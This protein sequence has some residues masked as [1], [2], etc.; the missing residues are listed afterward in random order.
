MVHPGAA[1]SLVI[2]TRGVDSVE[3]VMVVDVEV[4]RVDADEGAVFFVELFDLEA[5]SSRN[6]TRTRRLELLAFALIRRALEVDG[7]TGL[8]SDPE[9]LREGGKYMR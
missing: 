5:V 1:V 7:W 2:C 8:L 4:Y 3:V 9:T 6:E